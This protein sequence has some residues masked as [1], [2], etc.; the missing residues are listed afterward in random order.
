MRVALGPRSACLTQYGNFW[1]QALQNAD[2]FYAQ[3]LLKMTISSLRLS[4]GMF[5]FQA[6]SFVYKQRLLNWERRPVARQGRWYLL[7]G[8]AGL[9][10]RPLRDALLSY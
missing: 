4:M 1:G 2:G 9:R 7:M 5:V 8:R 10:P 3:D 6:G